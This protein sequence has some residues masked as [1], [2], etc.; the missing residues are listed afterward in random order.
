[1]NILNPL[2]ENY[3]EPK[4]ISE[5]LS[6]SEITEQEYYNALTIST[7]TD[8]QIHL[9]RF[10]NSCFI[11]NYFVDGLL[12]W[13]ANLDIQPVFN[14]YKAVSYMYA[15]FSKS[16]A[17]KQAAM[18]AKKMNHDSYEQMKAI[19]RAYLTKRECS[20]QE[21]VY[22]IMPELWLIKSYP[23]VIFA[24]SNLPG[25][26]FRICLSEEEINELPDERTDIFK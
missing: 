18:E 17:M 2:K 9:K 21:A 20:V 3:I 25:N 8:F 23:R 15:Y 14:H 4:S 12:A 5:I 26:R 24:N 16:E 1:M 7:D 13:E 22:H 10:P 11:N 6:A 19:S